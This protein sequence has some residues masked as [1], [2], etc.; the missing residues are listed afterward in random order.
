MPLKC[1][2]FYS[3]YQQ[4]EKCP[5]HRSRNE[6]DLIIITIICRESKPYGATKGYS[7][8]SNNWLAQTYWVIQC[9]TSGQRCLRMKPPPYPGIRTLPTWTRI[10]IPCSRFLPG[11]LSLTQTGRT[12]VWRWDHKSRWSF[13]CSICFA[14]LKP[15]FHNFLKIHFCRLKILFPTLCSF[16][17]SEDSRGSLRSLPPSPRRG[18]SAMNPGCQLGLGKLIYH[19][20]RFSKRIR[21]QKVN[22]CSIKLIFP[23]IFHSNIFWPT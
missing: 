10:H 22:Y 18:V 5:F 2:I 15:A 13:P 6:N 12:A 7:M 16:N 19:I 20:P 23:P 9:G 1:K 3:W 17:N 4:S 14:P 11:S 21:A 8:W